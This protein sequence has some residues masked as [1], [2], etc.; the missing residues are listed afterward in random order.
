MKETED[1]M[2]KSD[3]KNLAMLNTCVGGK[4]GENLKVKVGIHNNV[5][6]AG[7]EVSFAVAFPDAL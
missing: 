7:S 6:Y 5:A 3:H 2:A 4:L 1:F